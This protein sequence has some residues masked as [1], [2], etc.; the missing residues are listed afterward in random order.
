MTMFIIAA[1][2]ILV[3]MLAMMADCAAKPLKP[4]KIK[5]EEQHEYIDNDLRL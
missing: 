1:A 5:K 2:M 3:I 4:C